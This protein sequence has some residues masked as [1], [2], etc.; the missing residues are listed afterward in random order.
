MVVLGY[1]STSSTQELG[2][3][4]A[5]RDSGGKR[6]RWRAVAVACGMELGRAL[7]ALQRLGRAAAWN[8]QDSVIW[9]TAA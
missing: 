2:Q 6:L 8:E 4:L 1:W 3:V 7:A 5:V 9:S